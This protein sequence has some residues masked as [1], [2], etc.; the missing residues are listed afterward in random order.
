MKILLLSRDSEIISAL[1]D[2]TH[3]T[4]DNLITVPEIYQAKKELGSHDCD[5]VLMDCSIRPTEL[6]GLAT[7]MADELS[8]TV[9]LLLGPLDHEQREQLGRR[10]SAHYSIDKPLRGKAF[11]ET[12]HRVTMRSTIV[13]GR[14]LITVFATI[15]TMIVVFLTILFSL[16]FARKLSNPVEPAEPAQ[17]SIRHAANC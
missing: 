15:I 8:D 9:V 11:F 12:M 6:I 10:L 13:R 5:S 1:Q 14:T 3:Q 2:Y 4:G 7:E 16:Q 17:S